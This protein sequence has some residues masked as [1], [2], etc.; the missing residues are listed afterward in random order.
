MLF[1]QQL[2]KIETLKALGFK[3]LALALA[4]AFACLP[5]PEGDDRLAPNACVVG[6]DRAIADAAAAVNMLDD[7][8]AALTFAV[9]DDR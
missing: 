1:L 8:G 9:A 4:L 2:G 7:S 5:V 3:A 6:H